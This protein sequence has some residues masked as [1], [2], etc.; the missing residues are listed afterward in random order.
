M[1]QASLCYIVKHCP[2]KQTNNQTATIIENKSSIMAYKGEKRSIQ[3]MAVA[4][5]SVLRN[6][7][8]QGTKVEVNGQDPTVPSLVSSL[9]SAGS[10]LQHPLRFLPIANSSELGTKPLTQFLLW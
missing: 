7:S 10:S 8:G 2:I 1:F 3:F 5:G 4:L 6:P 9:W